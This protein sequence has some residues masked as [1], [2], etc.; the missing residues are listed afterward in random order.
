M[1]HHPEAQIQV[2]L[3]IPGGKL[4]PKL[5]ITR[6]VR[7]EVYCSVCIITVRQKSLSALKEL[8]AKDR[9]MM[10]SICEHKHGA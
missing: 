8:E 6:S 5:V 1:T 3:G 4:T 10:W 7:D 2:Y 9:A